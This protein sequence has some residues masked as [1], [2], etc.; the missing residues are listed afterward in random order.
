MNKIG[1]FLETYKFMV[2]LSKSINIPEMI[3]K[4]S[5]FFNNMKYNIEFQIFHHNISIYFNIENDFSLIYMLDYSTHDGNL[6]LTQLNN[7][8]DSNIFLSKDL[9]TELEND[10]NS[11]SELEFVLVYG[12]YP[13][14]IKEEFYQILTKAF[15]EEILKI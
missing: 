13:L 10:C 15:K 7:G 6:I 5:M 2:E 4:K 9:M 3:Y 8:S 14:R 1:V 12:R 11:M